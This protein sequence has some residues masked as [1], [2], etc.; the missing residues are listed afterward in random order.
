M[1]PELAI[2]LADLT[3]LFSNEYDVLRGGAEFMAV[4]F[5]SNRGMYIAAELRNDRPAYMAS[6]P[7]V[8]IQLRRPGYDPAQLT[9]IGQAE[10]PR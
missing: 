1:R 3:Q 2:H 5:T 9:H 4:E 8:S 6:A 7:V 10:K